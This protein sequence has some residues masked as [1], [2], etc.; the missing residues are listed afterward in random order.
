[1]AIAG[2]AAV[3]AGGYALWHGATMRPQEDTD[4][5]VLRRRRLRWFLAGGGLVVFGVL[6]IRKAS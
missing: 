5:A 2:L 6:A 1:L 3:G 4:S